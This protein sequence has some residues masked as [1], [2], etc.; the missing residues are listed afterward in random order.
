MLTALAKL[1]RVLNSEAD[2][3]QISLALAIAMAVGFL[4]FF[5]PLNLVLLFFVLVLRVNL[6]AFLLGTVFFSGVGYLLDPL[7]AS[8]GLHALASGALRGL[9]TAL[10][11][12]TVFRLINFNNTAVMGSIIVSA[13]LFIPLVAALNV[14]IR[15]YREHILRWV[16]KSRVMQVF[17]ATNFYKLYRTYS[18]IR[19]GL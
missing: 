6:S 5:S 16:E 4:P 13:V 3:L 12:T 10:Y 8:I 2:P 18:E 9:W 14:L 11:N 1:L 15:Q 7:F 19:S 17:K